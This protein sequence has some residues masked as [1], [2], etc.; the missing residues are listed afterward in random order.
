MNVAGLFAGIG[1]L[2][3]GL[4]RSGHHCILLSEVLPTAREVLAERMP[5]VDLRGDVRELQ[6]L[7]EDVEIV[8]AGFP[9]Q[10]L[11]QAGL[12]AGLDGARS[13]LV[14]EVFRLWSCAQVAGF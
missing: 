10:D 13:G 9:C 7:P 3:I 14:G 8:T 5:D 2:E 12:T 1:G 4:A 11:S 6:G